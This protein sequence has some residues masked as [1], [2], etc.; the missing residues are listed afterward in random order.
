MLGDVDFEDVK[1]EAEVLKALGSIALSRFRPVFQ[2]A[3]F[4]SFQRS[5]SYGIQ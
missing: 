3:E 5:A 1:S 4:T 2:F